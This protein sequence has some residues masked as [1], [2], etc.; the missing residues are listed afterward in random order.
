MSGIE[1]AA[2]AEGRKGRADDLRE[3]SAINPLLAGTLRI[4]GR[5]T[6]RGVDDAALLQHLF[7]RFA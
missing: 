4:A 2:R 3:G 1:K 6:N 5:R 7:D